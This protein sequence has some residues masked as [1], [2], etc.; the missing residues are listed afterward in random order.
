MTVDCAV[1]II[2]IGELGLARKSTN[3]P[4]VFIHQQSGPEFSSSKEIEEA[5]ISSVDSS[6]DLA[7]RPHENSEVSILHPL[8]LV[9]SRLGSVYHQMLK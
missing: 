6:E 8:A 2:E 1:Q 3:V 5:M 9:Y 7:V 4:Q